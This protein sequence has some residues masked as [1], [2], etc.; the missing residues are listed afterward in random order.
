MNQ[1]DKLF[2]AVGNIGDRFL[3]EASGYRAASRRYKK[4]WKAGLAAA[5]CLAVGVTAL[6]YRGNGHSMTVYAYESNQ[7]LS[8]G[9]AVTMPGTITDSGSMKGHPLMFYISGKGIES[10]RFSCRDG[11]ISFM[12]WTEQREDYGFSK[13]FTVTYGKKEEEYYYL[14]VYWTPQS[15][16]RKLTDNP[17]IGIADLSQE[18]KEDIIVMEVKYLNGDSETQAIS[19][20][21]SEDGHFL[22]SVTDY[23]ITAA[24]E[25]V[26]RED[27]AS[28]EWEPGSAPR[29]ESGVPDQG[30]PDA[31]E[32]GTEPEESS[33]EAE[34]SRAVS[35]S[36]EQL[37]CVSRA[38]ED[39]YASTV[40]KVISYSQ[41]DRRGFYYRE[42][43]GYEEREVVIFDVTVEG[44]ETTRSI[45]V[46]SKDNWKHCSI[47]NEGY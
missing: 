22:A 17:Q 28:Q 6:L 16:I 36:E 26:F 27:R 40:F 41:S 1:A 2:T 47:L 11:W 44:S 4:I 32:A 5:V 15:I 29:E 42:Y 33:G 23:E 14:V 9:R 12:D 46:G 7:E 8:G 3:Q 30:E 37:D 18:E 35:L 24:D 31:G 21:L 39:Y 20:V 45:A 10:I 25:F 13:N 43:E 34:D 38:I 19:I